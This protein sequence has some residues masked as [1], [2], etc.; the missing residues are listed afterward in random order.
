MFVR[1][2]FSQP[3]IDDG[4]APLLNIVK[5]RIHNGTAAL[6]IVDATLLHDIA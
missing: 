1:A 3:P 5:E 6:R 2:I 4:N